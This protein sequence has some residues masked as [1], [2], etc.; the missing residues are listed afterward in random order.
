MELTF[1]AVLQAVAPYA[2]KG[3]SCATTASARLFALRAIEYLAYKGGSG[4]LCKWCF[5]SC[6]KCFVAPHDLEVP[7]R[8]KVDDLAE[9]IYSKWYDFYDSANQSDYS[10]SYVTV[11]ED[12]LPAFTVHN[13]PVGGAFISA[14]SLEKEDNATITVQGI[15]KDGQPIYTEYKGERI[16]GET[17]EVNTEDSPVHSTKVFTRITGIQCTKTK[18]RKR[19]FWFVNAPVKRVGLLAE[20]RPNEVNPRF[21]KFLITDCS[22]A[23]CHKITILGRAR[24]LSDYHDNE[25]V[26]ITSLNAA[27]EAAQFLQSKNNNDINV[28]QFKG[29]EVERL[30]NDEN[31]YMKFGQE[32]IEFLHATSPGSMRHIR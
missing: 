15:G 6:D 9:P 29:Q 30:V 21:R 32:P 27:I 5:Y 17:L 8:I 18:N 13:L 22:N 23:C 25:I 28:A 2:G 11:K 3:G 31:E 24:V 26:P 4:T 1:G 10:G 14:T 12:A 16:C 19:L 20:Y 7:I